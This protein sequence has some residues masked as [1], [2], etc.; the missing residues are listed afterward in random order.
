MTRPT[1]PASVS[2]PSSIEDQSASSETT[3]PAPRSDTTSLSALPDLKSLNLRGNFGVLYEDQNCLATLTKL[4]NL[5]LQDTDLVAEELLNLK[6]LPKL[7]ELNILENNPNRFCIPYLSQLKQLKRLHF[8]SEYFSKEDWQ[9]LKMAL[10]GVEIID[11]KS[12]D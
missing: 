2:R 12:Y 11:F 6:N 10:P 4:T 7:S 3:V 1:K 9:Q 8:S 5:S